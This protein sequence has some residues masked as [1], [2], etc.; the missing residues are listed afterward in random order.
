MSQSLILID[1]L[2]FVCW[3]KKEKKE[4]KKRNKWLGA[5]GPRPEA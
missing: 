1:A 5:F 4:E 2:S 3:E